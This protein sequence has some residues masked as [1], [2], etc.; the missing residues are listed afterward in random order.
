MTIYF[1]ASYNLLDPEREFRRAGEFSL[2]LTD[3]AF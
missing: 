1:D 3:P 2:F